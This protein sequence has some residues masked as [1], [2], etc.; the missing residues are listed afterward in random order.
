MVTEPR[1]PG[2]GSSAAGS[3]TTRSIRA[4]P[5]PGSGSA[6]GQGARRGE[7]SERRPEVAPLP[8]VECLLGEPE[9]AP[10]APAD[11]DQD[12]RPGWPR[13]ERDQ[14]D[15]LA[16]EPDVPSEDRPAEGHEVVGDQVLGGIP[17]ALHRRPTRSW[18]ALHPASL[19]AP[20]YPGVS[21]DR[22][23]PN[24]GCVG[25]SALRSSAP[26]PSAGHAAADRWHTRP[27]AQALTRTTEHATAQRQARIA[28][29]ASGSRLTLSDVPA[30]GGPVPPSP[31]PNARR[32]GSE[33][34]RHC[35][36]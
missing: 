20:A 16:P 27:G 35:E 30:Q 1:G 6:V 29:T 23:R 10:R 8:P 12:D 24:G 15:L 3:T 34:A 33:E 28:L 11:L 18:S 13:V 14:V 17:G 22:P 9:V 31:C 4:R 2:P 25:A 21:R 26:V 36:W 7:A 32:S 5:P 19:A